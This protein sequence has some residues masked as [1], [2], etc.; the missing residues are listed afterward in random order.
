MIEISLTADRGTF[1]TCG[2]DDTDPELAAVRPLAAPAAVRLSGREC[3]AHANA[4]IF[5][6]L[7]SP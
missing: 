5:G 6:W 1:T 3:K 7:V 2:S 4:V